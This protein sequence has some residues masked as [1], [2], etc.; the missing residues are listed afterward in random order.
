MSISSSPMFLSCHNL[1]HHP[2]ITK[3]IHPSLSLHLIIMSRHW[4]QHI[5]SVAY[6]ELSLNRVQHPPKIA[7][8]SS[9]IK[10]M[11][12]ILLIMQDYKSLNLHWHSLSRWTGEGIDICV[13]YN[14]GQ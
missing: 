7:C 3:S 14:G 4:V 9:I 2:M 8:D 13:S 11:T 6:T 5:P 12:L 1:C 10:N